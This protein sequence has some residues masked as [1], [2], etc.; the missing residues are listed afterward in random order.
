MIDPH[1]SLPASPEAERGFLCSYLLAPLEIGAACSERLVTEDYFHEPS[2]AAT[3]SIL[4]GMSLAER[5]IDT[6]TVFEEAHRRG[7]VATCGGPTAFSELWGFMPTPANA[8]HY[9]EILQE[10]RLLREI[11]RVGSEFAAL[12]YEPATDAAATLAAFERAALG[13][14]AGEQKPEVPF[15]QHLMNAINRCQERF[16]RGNGMIGLP[17]GLTALD[18]LT[19]GLAAPDLIVVSAETSGGKT[20]LACGFA[21]AAAVIAQTPVAIFSYEMT[22]EE[23]TDRILV[24][25]SRVDMMRYRQ[26]WLKEMDFA[27]LTRGESALAEAKIFLRDDSEMNVMQIRAHARRLKRKHG[28]GLLVIDYAQLVPESS[29][30]KGAN[31]EQ[32]VAFISRQC[33]AMAKEIQCPVVLLS[34]LNDEG[35]IRESRAITHDANMILL[36]QEEEDKKTSE[37]RHYIRIAKQRNGPRD[38]LPVTFLKKYT[39]FQDYTPERQ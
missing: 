26:G 7:L 13:I 14:Q 20:A 34:Q 23:I 2:N 8:A 9:L 33:K 1:R 15:K 27:N 17:T 29:G 4:R 24:S 6:V 32:E 39:L 16:E 12:A 28:I 11:A 25:H 19:G 35:K 36:I 30:K 5:R 22:N 3:F 18:K 38:R 10:K 21:V 37:T 31:R